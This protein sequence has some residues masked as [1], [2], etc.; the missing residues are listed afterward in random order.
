MTSQK[1]IW[2]L[3]FWKQKTKITEKTLKIG[4]FYLPE[5]KKNL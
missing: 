1:H 5:T 3:K 2:C 4:Q